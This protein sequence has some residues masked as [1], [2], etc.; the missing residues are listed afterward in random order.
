MEWS[1][2]EDDAQH[3]QPAL[4]CGRRLPLKLDPAVRGELE[5]YALDLPPES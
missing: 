4:H 2:H 3:G 1:H 5:G